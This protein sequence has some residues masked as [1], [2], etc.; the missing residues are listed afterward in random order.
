[1]SRVYNLS[2]ATFSPDQRYRYS[3]S[4]RWK[5]GPRALFVMLNPSTADADNPDPTITRCLGFADAIGCG[6]LD[7]ANL[8]AF[9]STDPDQLIGRWAAI[10]PRNDGEILALA[11]EADWVICAW[12]CHVSVEGPTGSPHGGRGD[13]VATML[14]DAGIKL[15]ALRL[16][17]KGFPAHPLF[18]PGAL[19]PQSFHPRFRHG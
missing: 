14:L 10:G 16:T 8:F 1:M 11:K 2:T 13:A 19:R 18:L 17:Q 5:E 7:V 9:R 3:L 6:R 15:H 12:G 4:R